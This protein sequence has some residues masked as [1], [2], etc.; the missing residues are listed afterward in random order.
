[1]IPEH[2]VNAAAL[3]EMPL[4]FKL[5]ASTRYV[6]DMYAG[7]DYDNDLDTLED[8]WLLDL[9]VRY[10]PGYISGDLELYVGV[11]NVLN[12]IYASTGFDWGFVVYYP[13]EGR[14]WKVGGSYRY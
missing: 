3:V 4:D 12:K 5:G 2:S 10:N 14:S 6:S 1:L 7:G 11:S 13:G 9:F 8:Y